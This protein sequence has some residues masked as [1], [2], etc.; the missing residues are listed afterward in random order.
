MPVASELGW[1]RGGAYLHG[2]GARDFFTV[3]LLRQE[4]MS[5]PF[6]NSSHPSGW[7]RL[8]R[9]FLFSIQ[10]PVSFLFLFF[11]FGFFSSLFITS[12]I[13]SHIHPLGD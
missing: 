6:G 9:V 5:N 8:W 10:T 1:G 12:K 3:S 13:L 4:I 11:P 7:R 2:D